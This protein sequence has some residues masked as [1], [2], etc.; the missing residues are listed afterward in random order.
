MR[1]LGIKNWIV[2]VVLLLTPLVLMYAQKRNPNLLHP[3]S[4]YLLDAVF[5][6]QSGLLAVSSRISDGL[7]AYRFFKWDE[8]ENLRLRARLK[9]HNFLTILL[10]EAELENQRLKQLMNHF[11]SGLPSEPIYA[12]VIGRL[13]AP[14]SRLIELNVGSEDHI[15]R[16]DGVIGAAG[17]VGRVILVSKYTCQVLL[18]TDVSSSV[19]VMVQRTRER[20]ILHG[21]TDAQSYMFQVDN[22]DRLAQVR[23]GDVV[24]TSGVGFGLPAGV[25]VGRVV[26]VG[27]SYNKLY[28]EA[29]I[30]PFINYN[31]LQNVLVLRGGMMGSA[32]SRSN[33]N[34]LAIEQSL[35]YPP[36][37]KQ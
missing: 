24:L 4:S 15:K 2:V 12:D 17:A 14:L 20:G 36:R 33:L 1:F 35:E 3:V 32:W 31:T 28:R 21:T 10:K 34:Q 30:E 5:I 37:K 29:K 22:F 23:K 25:P 18:M 6:I 8:Q 26:R 11:P 19:D 9:Q 7:Y 27:S 13:G 16:G